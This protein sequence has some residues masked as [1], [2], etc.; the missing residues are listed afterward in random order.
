[1]S[2]SGLRTTLIALAFV[3]LAVGGLRFA[4]DLTLRLASAGFVALA[5]VFGFVYVAGLLRAQREGRT[6]RRSL[7]L[8]AFFVAAL[9]LKVA[10]GPAIPRSLS[11]PILVITI[12]AGVWCYLLYLYESRVMAGQ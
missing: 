8:L 10:V 11:L 5:V 6:P 2:P 1:M 4:P 12:L 7:H 3:A 9:L